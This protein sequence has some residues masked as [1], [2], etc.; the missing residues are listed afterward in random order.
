MA[1]GASG[2]VVCWGYNDYG[3]TD[4]PPGR[5]EAVSASATRTCAISKERDIVCW[6]NV[7][8]EPANTLW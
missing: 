3:Q 8:Y 7:E 1:L 6:G 5:Y 2:D 4:V